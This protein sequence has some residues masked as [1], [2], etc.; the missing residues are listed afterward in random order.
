MLQNKVIGGNLYRHTKKTKKN[1]NKEKVNDILLQ[2]S[3]LLKYKE[4]VFI[5]L[6]LGISKLCARVVGLKTKLTQIK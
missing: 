6:A 3:I 2:N 5:G 1:K 4:N